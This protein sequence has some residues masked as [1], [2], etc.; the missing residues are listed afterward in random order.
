MDM[1]FTE[2]KLKGAYII[3]P[4]KLEDDRGYFARSFCRWEFLKHGLN[5]HIVQCSA[6]YNKVKGTFRGMHY[7]LPPFEE[8]KIVSCVHGAVLDFIV[9]LRKDSATF[10]QCISVELSEENGFMLYIPRLFAHGFLT[11]QDD[12]QLF[13]QMT[14]YHHPEYAKGF[15]FDDPA[16]EIPLPF[17]PVVISRKDKSY[18]NI[19]IERKQLKEFV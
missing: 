14:Q 17:D 18:P 3:K 12:T 11:L 19:K 5:S 6:S 1:I 10:G 8:D 2:T 16:F 9:D 7:Q 15:R 13:Y 4:E